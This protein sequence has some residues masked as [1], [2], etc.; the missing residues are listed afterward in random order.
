MPVAALTNADPDVAAE[1]AA[2]HHGTCHDLPSG[3]GYLASGQHRAVYVDYDTDT[4]YKL[5]R[6]ERQES[7]NRQEHQL[8][9]E[10]REAGADWAPPTDLIEVTVTTA[11]GEFRCTVVA[12]PYLPED[13]SVEH[14]GAAIPIDGDFNP[15]NVVANGGQL[16]L[17][18]AGGM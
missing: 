10:H 1:I 15:S 16:W 6:D 5:A 8:L 18:D 9:T 3:V 11:W 12:M 4:A 7:A 13:W 14:A 17:I 2:Y